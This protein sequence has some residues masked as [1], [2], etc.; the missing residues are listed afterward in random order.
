M[1]IH[2]LNVILKNVSNYKYKRGFINYISTLSYDD[3]E[4]LLRYYMSALIRLMLRYK[5]R[6]ANFLS[7]QWFI[8]RKLI[9]KYRKIG[10]IFYNANNNF[11]K[12]I[13]DNIREDNKIKTDL[14]NNI[15]E[16]QNI[17]NNLLKTKILI[18]DMKD[19]KEIIS[20]CGLTI[21]IIYANKELER[22][23]EELGKY[24]RY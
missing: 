12:K 24:E 13:D 19:E 11:C 20:F 6:K 2:R 4:Y 7:K 23:Y 22:L 21:S 18:T 5:N 16:N 1:K 15:R 17:L 9:L 8:N 10:T 3:Y 14:L